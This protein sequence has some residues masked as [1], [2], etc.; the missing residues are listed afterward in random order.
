MAR[1]APDHNPPRD[2]APRAPA[3]R[4]LSMAVRILSRTS[5]ALGS[6]ALCALALSSAAPRALAQNAQPQA[7][8]VGA[9]TPPNANQ[10]N[11]TNVGRVRSG[12]ARLFSLADVKAQVLCELPAG[13]P[14]RVR[15]Q[16]SGWL[17]VE[18]AGGFP[19]WVFG[20]YLAPGERP[21][22][23]V[24]QGDRV[25][26]RPVPSKDAANSFPV[27][28]LERGTR[29]D[30]LA[31]QNP[32]LPLA[33]DWV[34]VSAPA[35]ASAWLRA[36]Q[37]EPMPAGA[38]FD[39]EWNAARAARAVP[40]VALAGSAPNAAPATPATVEASAN[41]AAPTGA[42]P[43]PNQPAAQGTSSRELLERAQQLLEATRGQEQPD[44][45]PV[46]AAFDAVLANEGQGAQSVIA[47]GARKG[48]EAIAAMEAALAQRGKLAEERARFESELPAKRAEIRAE[49]DKRNPLAGL[50]DAH[51]TLVRRAGTDGRQVWWL[52]F[53]QK[54]VCEIA[55][56]SGRYDLELYAG[57]NIG[58]RGALIGGS[59]GLPRID[60]QRIEVLIP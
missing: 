47:Q 46:R 13:T 35:G 1:A 45:A 3:P 14:L 9:Q 8:A 23:A 21:D 10:T 5:F 60:V 6:A 38:N 30:V 24:V 25:N 57:A 4:R 17:Q 54:D 29:L 53:A 11:P 59:T 39:A 56:S 58:V 44:F 19:A 12:G 51:G 50:Y 22:Q 20:A 41:A 33:E 43:N 37:T 31:R 36:E 2:S 42:N 48:L 40:G 18:P 27:A 15:G 26:L 34:R 55:C 32:T 52:S 16:N 28:T 49:A 7:P